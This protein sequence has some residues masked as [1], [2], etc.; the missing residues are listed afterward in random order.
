[1]G[2]LLLFQYDDGGRA[3]AGYRGRARDCATRAI[4]IATGCAYQDIYRA[5]A[6]EAAAEAVLRRNHPRSGLRKHTVKRY[7]NRIGWRWTATMHIGSG[8]RVHLRHGELPGGR[9]I[10]AVSKHVCAVIDG[11]LHDTHDCS[12][13]GRRCVY[14]YWMAS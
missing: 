13:G 2:G 8:C 7:L 9:L 3:A 10:V 14:G 6:E 11:V 5:L 1:M 12:R 4:A